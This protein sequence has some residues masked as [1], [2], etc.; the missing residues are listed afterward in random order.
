VIPAQEP[1]EILMIRGVGLAS[2]D[3][4]YVGVYRYTDGS[5]EFNGEFSQKLLDDYMERLLKKKT[6]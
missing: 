2:P 5:Y 3:E 6:R 1:Y 4:K